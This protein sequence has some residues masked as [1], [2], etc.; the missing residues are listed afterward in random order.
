MLY[1]RAEAAVHE[2]TLYRA[3]APSSG[4]SKSPRHSLLHLL[5]VGHEAGKWMKLNPT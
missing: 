2:V 3:E 1:G 4:I 5:K